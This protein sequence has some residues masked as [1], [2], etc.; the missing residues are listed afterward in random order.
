MV[1]V[2]AISP[3]LAGVVDEFVEDEVRAGPDG[4]GRAVHQED[5]HQPAASRVDALVEEDRLADVE[6]GLGCAGESREG[7]GI[8]GGSDPTLLARATLAS[9][10]S[11]TRSALATANPL[12]SLVLCI[13][14]NLFCTPTR[15]VR[16]SN[17]L[18]S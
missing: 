4:E 6:L 17:A 13:P 2:A 18:K 15:A 11:P 8:D 16:S 1:L 10:A 5:L 12:R 9:P 7:I 14:Q 3:V